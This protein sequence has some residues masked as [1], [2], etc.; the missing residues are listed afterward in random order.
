VVKVVMNTGYGY[1]KNL[2]ADRKRYEAEKDQVARTIIDQ[3][4]TFLSGIKKQVEVMDVAM[5]LT[6]ERYTGNWQGLLE[7]SLVWRTSIWLRSGQSA[8]YQLRFPGA[9]L[10]NPFVNWTK[11]QFLMTIP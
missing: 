3:L 7:N 1:W 2:A 4:E 5:P 6:F 10:S 11:K 9:D 8:W